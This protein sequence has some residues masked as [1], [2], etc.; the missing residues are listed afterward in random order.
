MVTTGALG[1]IWIAY[2]AIRR[3]DISTDR[4]ADQVGLALTLVAVLLFL[5]QLPNFLSA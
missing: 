1:A 5:S 2:K 4:V 3:E